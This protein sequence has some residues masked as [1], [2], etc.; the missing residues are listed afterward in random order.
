MKIPE[1]LEEC[2]IELDQS[3]GLDHR[4]KKGLDINLEDQFKQIKNF[5]YNKFINS[6]FNI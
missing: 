4:Y 2:Y 3:E 6:L 1:T 5:D